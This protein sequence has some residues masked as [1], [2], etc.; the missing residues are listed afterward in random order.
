MRKRHLLLSLGAL[1]ALPGCG[2][3]GSG[4]TQAQTPGE[5]QS[6][7]ITARATGTTYP[8]SVFIPPSGTTR[9]S[10]LPVIVALDGESWFQTLT[11]VVATAA[12]P[13]IVVAVHTAGQ[14]GRDYVPANA[15]TAGGGGQD[16]YFRF[17]RDE[18][19]PYIAQTIGGASDKR[20]LFGHS[21]GGSFVLHALFAE[22]AAG[23]SFQAYLACDASVSC[24]PASAAQWEQAYADHN[25][26]LPVRLHLSYATM[27]NFQANA[28]YAALLAR[29]SYTGLRLLPQAYIG[30]HQGIVPQALADGLAFAMAAAP[31]A[32]RSTALHITP[33][34]HPP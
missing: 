8:L 2:G 22:P 13:A 25:R 14:R 21:H 26:A 30:S 34:P 27:G 11:E 15:C 20:V 32:Q 28:D 10:D 6:L 18:L 17:V 29:R 24:M 4:T 12:T 19:L 31:Q 33:D 3:G 16:D 1:L 23:H 7:S 5:F 9:R